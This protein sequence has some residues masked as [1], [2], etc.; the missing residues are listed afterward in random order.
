MDI[1]NLELEFKNSKI[2]NARYDKR[3]QVDFIF[4]AFTAKAFNLQ[5]IYLIQNLFTRAAIILVDA[6]CAEM[7]FLNLAEANVIK[8]DDVHTSYQVYEFFFVEIPLYKI[9]TVSVKSLQVF[10]IIIDRYQYPPSNFKLSNFCPVETKRL[11]S[12]NQELIYA[13]WGQCVK[14]L[15]KERLNCTSEL[16]SKNL[17]EVYHRELDTHINNF[18]LI[19]PHGV[20]DFGI[21][22]SVFYNAAN[23]RNIYALISPFSLTSWIA[24]IICSYVVALLLFISQVNFNPFFWLLTIILEQNCVTSSKFTHS[25]VF[26]VFVWLSGAFLLRNAYT[27][28]LY[29]YLS[30][31]LEPIDLPSSFQEILDNGNVKFLV[32]DFAS[33]QIDRYKNAMNYNSFNGTYGYEL[34]DLIVKK[35][36]RMWLDVFTGRFYNI[37]R[38]SDG[39]QNLCNHE[40][41]EV[42]VASCVKLDTFGY[43][44]TISS[45][46]YFSD[47]LQDFGK[48]FLLT[49]NFGLKLSLSNEISTFQSRYVFVFKS[50]NIFK[51]RFEIYMA[52]V[53]QSGINLLQKKY[54]GEGDM[55]AYLK[56]LKTVYSTKN[57]TERNISI[58]KLGYYSTLWIQNNCY[59]VYSKEKC[60]IKSDSGDEDEIPVKLV[61]LLVVWILYAGLLITTIAVFGQECF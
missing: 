54:M 14:E 21:R 26:V 60:E 20:E 50:D 23:A 59:S 4:I 44:T 48:L 10:K 2:R 32:S 47:S 17:N 42:D 28:N 38:N 27:S 19:S 15:I 33:I 5:T 46:D 22:Y 18:S 51:T 40:S 35:A 8:I 53:E 25:D 37:Q 13:S 9:E 52:A 30:V 6:Y 55:K 57:V 58:E 16:C 61:D 49:R 31:E 12:P 39:A 24:I 29:T 34:A 11:R 41:Y 45:G 56:L 3:N 1:D 36:W 7:Y 43:V